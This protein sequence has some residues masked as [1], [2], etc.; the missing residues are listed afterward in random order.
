MTGDI[1]L[2]ELS[3]EPGEDPEETLPARAQRVP[4]WWSTVPR[5]PRWQLASQRWF[6]AGLV[7]VVV[8]AAVAVLVS[9]SGR[10]SSTPAAALSMSVPPSPEPAPTPV[11]REWRLQLQQAYE[12]LDPMVLAA[13]RAEVCR[14]STSCLYVPDSQRR[15]AR[16][17]WMFSMPGQAGG[18]ILLGSDGTTLGRGALVALA[19]GVQYSL[20]VLRAHGP[21]LPQVNVNRGA[22]GGMVTLTARRGSWDLVSTV[23]FQGVVSVPMGPARTW[24]ASSTL[25][26]APVTGPRVPA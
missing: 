25:P 8:A 24:L 13:L 5:A 19:S 6:G 2:I 26:D 21:A 18:G 22:D 12:P 15:L 9:H 16:Y 23:T 11:A 14:G 20:T 7:C 1:E 3:P 10:P 4:Q 17:L